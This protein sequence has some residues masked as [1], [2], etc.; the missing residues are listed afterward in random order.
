MPFLV[1]ML[2]VRAWGVDGGWMPLPTRPQQYCGLTSLVIMSELE[3]TS[4][5]VATTYLCSPTNHGNNNHN[6]DWQ[7]QRREDGF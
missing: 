5:I 6:A 3:G 7:Q 2:V 1:C 4:L